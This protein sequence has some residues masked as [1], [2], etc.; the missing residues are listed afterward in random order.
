MKNVDHLI[1]NIGNN[2][3]EIRRAQKISQQEMAD[4]IGLSL[5][6]YGRME[7]GVANASIATI[8]KVAAHLETG[9][10]LLVYGEP[11]KAENPTIQLKETSL[12]EKMKELED[13]TPPDSKL[14][15]QVLDLII[16]KKKLDKLVKHIHAKK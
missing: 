7:T 6:Q 14:A 2:I 5:S 4:K 9:I 13:L 11:I 12:V 10:D 8:I 3:R 15:H 1:A 16:A